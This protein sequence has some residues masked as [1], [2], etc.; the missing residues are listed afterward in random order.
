MEYSNTTEAC[1]HTNFANCTHNKENTFC[2]KCIH[3]YTFQ[4]K[5][6]DF[7]TYTS[8]TTNITT[9]YTILNV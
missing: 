5:K 6:I 1:I 3:R 2:I 4:K 7:K 8:T 9:T